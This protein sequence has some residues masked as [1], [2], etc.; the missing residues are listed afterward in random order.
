MNLDELIQA[1]DLIKQQFDNLSNANWVAA[2]QH[3][4]RG[5]YDILDEVIKEQEKQNAEN[6]EEKP[7]DSNNDKG[8]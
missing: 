1:R 3:H 2:E 8:E 6:S 4:L 7:A 5:K